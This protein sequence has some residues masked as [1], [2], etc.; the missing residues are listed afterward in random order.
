MSKR[1]EANKGAFIVLSF[2]IVSIKMVRSSSFTTNIVKQNPNKVNQEDLKMKVL[3]VNGS[4]HIHGTTMK[5][6]EEMIKIFEE[7]KIETEVIQLGGKPLADC[8]QCNS[9]QKQGNVCSKR[10]G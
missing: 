3:L 9:C 1:L 4:S 5:A 2:L 7:E 8:T 6:L 10:M